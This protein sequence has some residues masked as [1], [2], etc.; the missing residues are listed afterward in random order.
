MKKEMMPVFLLIL[1]GLLIRVFLI[2][3]PVEIGIDSCSYAGL[4]RK[5]AL[6]EAYFQP[7]WPPLYSY[8]IA[9]VSPFASNFEEAGRW[10]SVLF[11]TGV[12]PLIYFLGRYFFSHQAGMIALVFAVFEPSLLYFSTAV[13]SESQ[14][15]FLFLIVFCVA[16]VLIKKPAFFTAVCMGL[17]FGMLYLTRVEGAGYLILFFLVFIYMSF[18]NRQSAVKT[19]ICLSF[20]L[21]SFSIVSFPYWNYL[22]ESTGKWTLSDKSLLHLKT[23]IESVK[24]DKLEGVEKLL[25]KLTDDKTDL[26]ARQLI[27][28]TG[29]KED[30]KPKINEVAYMYLRNIGVFLKY[31]LPKWLPPLITILLILGIYTVLRDKHYRLKWRWILPVLIYVFFTAFIYY[32]NRF[33]FVLIPFALILASAGLI[34]F[35]KN[36]FKFEKGIVW[37][38]ILVLLTLIPPVHSMISERAEA[39][40]FR[41]QVG[42]WLMQHYPEG[43]AFISRYPQIPFYGHTESIAFPY[44]EMKDIFVYAQAQKA[45]GIIFQKSEIKKLRPWLSEIFD[46]PDL[47]PEMNLVFKAKNIK[48][49]VE[50]EVLIFEFNFKRRPV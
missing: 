14:F 2:Y 8:F 48:E 39:G 1:T 25:F 12:L 19:A 45:K 28:R 42:H 7:L 38:S 36:I 17:L 10:V 27:N 40:D 22:K 34:Y 24:A 43:G 46:K 15:L 3:L 37:I 32:Q 13:L 20:I 21:I 23:G 6:K 5:V 30:L 4:A 35:L 31:G 18:K 26:K 33:L 16:G 49:G 50:E 29:I 44:A 9:V 47:Y 11:G 41:K